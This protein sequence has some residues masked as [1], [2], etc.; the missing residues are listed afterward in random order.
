LCRMQDGPSSSSSRPNRRGG[1]ATANGRM[2]AS[3]QST[4]RSGKEFRDQPVARQERA[5]RRREQPAKV[6]KSVDEMIE[7]LADLERRG[8]HSTSQIKANLEASTVTLEEM[9]DDD[10]ARLVDVL[11]KMCLESDEAVFVVDL[12]PL[13]MKYSDFVDAFRERL[14]RV[15]SEYVLP[16][17]AEQMEGGEGERK[18]A[19]YEQVPSFLGS[20]LCARW[21]RGMHRDTH[22]SNPLLFTAFEIVRGWMLVVEEGVDRP[23]EKNKKEEKK[24]EIV[25]KVEEEEED[26]SDVEAVAEALQ[27]NCRINGEERLEEEDQDSLADATSSREDSIVLLNR[28]CS[29]LAAICESQQRSLWL[30]RP[31]LVD[32]MYKCIKQAITH[33]RDIDGSVKSSLLHTYLLMNEWTRSKAVTMKTVTTQT[34]A[35]Q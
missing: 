29:G 18:K 33:N 3:I 6:L 35:S 2:F 15:S 28:C 13:F 25:K 30:S 10:W 26:E 1:A 5:P 20:L 8:E 4:L 9:W 34:M 31:E 7:Q 12:L 19:R 22:E 14:I 32:D 17:E 16:S 11:I 24:T 23:D 21:P 27:E